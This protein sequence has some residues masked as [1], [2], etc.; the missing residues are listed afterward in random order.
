MSDIITEPETLQGQ[1]LQVAN[2]LETRGRCQHRL[3]D[4]AGRVCLLMAVV[5][6]VKDVEVPRVRVLI[7]ALQDEIDGQN[8]SRWNDAAGR[9]DDEVLTMVRNAAAKAEA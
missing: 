8:I 4:E 9:T 6:V 5:E 2:V 3:T 7:K 1:L